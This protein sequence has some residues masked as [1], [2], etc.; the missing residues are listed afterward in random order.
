MTSG[1]LPAKIT[2]LIILREGPQSGCRLAFDRCQW[3]DPSRCA[4]Q[5]PDRRWYQYFRADDWAAT[6]QGWTHDVA[7]AIRDCNE[8]HICVVERR[9]SCWRFDEEW[10]PECED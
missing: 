3:G 2:T 8:W 5:Y 7:R 9:R 4:L 10:D 6:G 1:S